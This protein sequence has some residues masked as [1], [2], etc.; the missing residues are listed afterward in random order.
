[1]NFIF[2]ILILP[3]FGVLISADVVHAAACGGVWCLSLY[4]SVSVCWFR[5]RFSCLGFRLPADIVGVLGWRWC[6]Y[7]VRV[8]GYLPAAVIFPVLRVPLASCVRVCCRLAGFYAWGC[9]AVMVRA[10]I[11]L[12]LELQ[13]YM[14][15]VSITKNTTILLQFSVSGSG[16]VWLGAAVDLY[17]G[18]SVHDES[19]LKNM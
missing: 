19:H 12:N 11:F 18:L 16:W 8:G 14:Q 9:Y 17:S 15:F 1:M 10:D 13:E 6:W 3:A 7:F 4:P 5:N 2:I